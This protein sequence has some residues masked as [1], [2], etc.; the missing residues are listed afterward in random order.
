MSLDT[1]REPLYQNSRFYVYDRYKVYGERIRKSY[2][3]TS[4]PSTAA[5]YEIG[6][7]PTET[8]AIAVADKM[9]RKYDQ[10]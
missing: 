3:V 10:I 8:W 5:K 9:E 2:R 7:Y 4:K 1:Q 6:I